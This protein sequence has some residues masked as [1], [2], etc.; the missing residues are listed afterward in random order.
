MYFLLEK[1]PFP[2]PEPYR[3]RCMGWNKDLADSDFIEGRH[4]DLT[5]ETPYE[6]ELREYTEGGNGLAEFYYE[7]F[8]LMRDDL[9]GVLQSAGVD[10]LQLYPAVL[11]DLK[12]GL[13]RRDYKVVNIVGKIAAADMAKSTYVDMGG[14]GM[15][16]VGFQDLVIDESKARA[17]RLFR[18]AESL[19][20][21]VIHESVKERL[22][23]AGFKYLRYLP[24]GAQ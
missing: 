9:I 1:D 21:V 2:E 20:S 16:A 24:C 8:P 4:L 18:L 13:E 15:I 19:T 23:T 14:L 7:A 3:T 11:R 22:E 12:T 5:V 10:N 17:Q 6:F